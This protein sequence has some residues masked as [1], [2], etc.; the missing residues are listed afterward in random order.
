MGSGK[1]I[2]FLGLVIGSSLLAPAHAGPTVQV[3]ATDP[4][5]SEVT[6]G[7]NQDFYLRLHYQADRPLRIWVR[8]YFQDTPVQ[9]GTNPSRLYPA[10]S[11]EALGWFFLFR[12]GT[13]V[14][15]VRISAGNGS[16]AGTR[17][18]A[19]YPV[20]ILGGN[21]PD[22]GQTRPDWVDRLKAFDAAAQ[23]AGVA[24]QR[25]EPPAAGETAALGGLVL[26]ALALGGAGLVAPWWGVWRWRGGWR[27]AAG[28]PAG[29]MAFV[30]LR[31]LFG[32]AEDPSSHNLWPFELLLAGVFNTAFMLILVATRKILGA[33]AP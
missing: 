15:E 21:L 5:G 20:E 27:I 6:L 28:G 29:L 26:G 22:E 1:V 25:G 8:P 13:R 30:L 31:L 24:R 12:P 23:E 17:V 3:V 7:R 9:A 2:G 16:R 33:E 4:A 18:V 32:V 10:G 11:G 19:T 14:D